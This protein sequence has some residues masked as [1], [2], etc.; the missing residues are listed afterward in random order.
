[1]KKK[2]L[3]AISILL[4]II[5]CFCGMYFDNKEL[6]NSISTIQNIVNNEIEKYEMSEEEIS[7]LSST[8]IIEQSV[9]DEENQEQEVENEAFELQGNIAYEG[10][11]ARSWDVEL[12]NYKG[13]TYYSQI[14]SRWKNKM[15]S[16][17]G[18][19]SQTI[20]GSGCGPTS[21]SMIVTACKGAITPDTMS[22][23]FVQY[24]YRSA[25]DGTY[26]SAFR[27]IADEFDINYK[28]TYN[29]DTAI[30]LLRNNHYIVASVGNGL[31]T[32]GGH[33][34]VLVGIDGDTIKVYDPYLYSG[35]FELSTRRGKATV[36]GNTVYVTVDNF[37]KYANYKCFFCYEHEAEV[38]ENN[39]KP[40]V[41]Q[42]YTRY[43]NVNTSLNVRAEPNTKSTI[44]A[45]LYN[46]DVVT[47]YENINNWSR[48]GDSRWVCSDYLS[49]YKK[50]A[51]QNTVNQTRKLAR[52]C[53]LYSNSNLSGIQYS[54]LKNTQVTILENVSSNIDKIRV[55]ATGRIAYI[56]TRN[57]TTYSTNIVKN[58]VNQYRR[59][60]VNCTLYSN[61]NLT[62][63]RYSYL[64]NTQ[65]KILRN[66]SSTV[67]YIYIPR[68]NRY[69]Y[70]RNNLYK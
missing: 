50:V 40:V 34:I 22:D 21:A 1:M 68:T 23:L 12:G 53:T 20:G 11:R 16:S 38:H 46:N 6:N 18:D 29:F 54:Y 32:T 30:N 63:V 9:E 26:W 8:E 24:G 25:N 58:T 44:V 35:K 51:V 48:I 33:F 57:Y 66:V 3:I 65:V 60:R 39:A 37:R 61:A 28:E 64:V 62:G 47:V 19:G 52:N 56:N 13:L 31:F 10:D 2:I 45:R 59:L 49:T 15:Y 7:E 5:G 4:M 17:I 14:D 36:S 41:T 70:I 55:N 27:A 43:V 67:D 42:S 69:A